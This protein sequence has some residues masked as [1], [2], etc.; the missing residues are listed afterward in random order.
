MSTTTRGRRA[1]TRTKE[2]VTAVV[3]EV[4][5]ENVSFMAGSVAYHAFVSL[6][7]FLLLLLLVLS[8]VGGERLAEEVLTAAAGYLTGQDVDVLVRAARSA[9]E[10]AG[11]SAVSLAVLVWGTLRIF[12][13]LDTAFSDIY[14]STAANTFLDQIRDG[15]VVF[16]AVG[17][18]ITAVSVADAVLVLPGSGAVGAVVRALATVAVVAVA[19]LPMYYVFPD[20]DVTVREVVPGTLVAAVGWTVL[21][22]G[23][24]YYAEV[25]SKTEYGVVGV[26]VLLVTWLYFT[27]FVLLLGAAVNAVLSGRSEDVP[28]IAWG[29]VDPGHEDADFVAP[30]RD[31]DAALDAGGTVTVT[32]GDETV[33]LPAPDEARVAVSTVERPA[34][35]GG[36]RER[37]EV[38]LR[39]DSWVRDARED[40]NEDE[41]Y[42]P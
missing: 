14:E 25:S 3:R 9:T 32:V 35:L 4:R 27:G 21:G 7:P 34:L 12:R 38:V 26:I 37:G 33:T 19:L 17:L 39:W 11:L 5:A 16:L 31:L 23:F 15:V 8:R 40:G 22:R 29:G 1:A 6:L 20:E 24:Q 30:L 18:G 13:G 28:D 2:V 42:P 10:N 36:D 41:D